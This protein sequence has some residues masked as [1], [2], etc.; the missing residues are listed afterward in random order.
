MKTT[1]QE[2]HHSH[3]RSFLSLALRL[4]ESLSVFLLV[5]ALL[6]LSLYI[7]GSYQD[8]LDSTQRLLL[9]LLKS[10]AGVSS[11]ASLYYTV[12]AAAWSLKRHHLL[13]GRL[14]FGAITALFGASLWLLVEMLVV[15]LGPY[16]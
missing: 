6:A 9:T 14:V 11:I 1:E 12:L 5:L 10:A 4:V 8:F 2:A 3:G 7:I 15:F 13:L 16:P